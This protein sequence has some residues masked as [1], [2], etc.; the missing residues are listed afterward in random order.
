MKWICIGAV[1]KVTV[2]RGTQL[3]SLVS[4]WAWPA[5]AI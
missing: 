2:R 1:A 3:V 4:K 5:N